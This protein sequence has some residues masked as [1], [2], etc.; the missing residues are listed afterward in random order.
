MWSGNRIHV[1]GLAIG[2][3]LGCAAAVVAETVLDAYD[4]PA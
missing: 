1:D 3:S 4:D 2:G